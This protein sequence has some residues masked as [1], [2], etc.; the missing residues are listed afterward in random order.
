MKFLPLSI[1]PLSIAAAILAAG[2]SAQTSSLSTATDVGVFANLDNSADYKF[3]AKDTQIRGEANVAARVGSREKAA[4]GASTT[5]NVKAA[6]SAV[7]VIV[8]ESAHANLAAAGKA[9][10]GT[11]SSNDPKNAKQGPHSFL[12]GYSAK[13]DSKWIVG[14]SYTGRVSGSGARASTE[15]DIGNN[16]SVEFKAAADGKTYRK[17][18]AVTAGDRGISVLMSTDGATAVTAA[19]SAG[20]K[21]S[22]I[23]SIR[24]ADNTTRRCTARAYGRSCGPVMVA[25]E[26]KRGGE[27]VLTFKTRN[28]KSPGVALFMIGA[29][30]AEILIPGTRCYLNL[31][32]LVCLPHAVERDGTASISFVIP[33]ALEGSWVNQD[34]TLSG[35]ARKIAIGM[36]NGIE[37]TC[38]KAQ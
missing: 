32:P 22:L 30:R 13:K 18:F 10:A 36:T 16:K 25:A 5:A 20:Y 3:I 21:A 6:K 35:D 14:V 26:S 24:P 28:A 2:L 19:G 12:L 4:A 15:V 1:A 27:T 8:N 17:E 11:S 29:E 37:I 38:K 7:S 31:K 33:K 9:S 23:V 34:A